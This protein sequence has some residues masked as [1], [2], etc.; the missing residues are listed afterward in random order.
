MKD[1]LLRYTAYNIWANN[2]L[3]DHLKILS[4]AE[5][6]HENG[7]SFSS[8]RKTIHHIYLAESIW[9]QRLNGQS[10]IQVPALQPSQPVAELCGQWAE[11][12]NAIHQFVHA[13]DDEQLFLQA[14]HYKQLNGELKQSMV[15]E[16]LQHVCN[17]SSVHRGQLIIY[18]RQAGKPALPSTDFITFCRLQENV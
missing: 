18:L 5:A 4:K 17:H 12:S 3:I 7:G 16:C 8:I 15:W 11:L 1:I 9:L 10:D 6:D 13:I 14:I 2:I